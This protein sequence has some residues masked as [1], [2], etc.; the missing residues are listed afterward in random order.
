MLLNILDVRCSVML[1]DQ[2]EQNLLRCTGCIAY[3]QYSIENVSQRVDLLNYGTTACLNDEMLER[4]EIEI[5]T[6]G[7]NEVV[8]LCLVAL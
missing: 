8:T 7:H 3:T 4:W 2:V 6:K 1:H 5:N